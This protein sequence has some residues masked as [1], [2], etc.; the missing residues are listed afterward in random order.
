MMKIE[1]NKETMFWD[2]LFDKEQSL[3]AF[4][5]IKGKRR[6]IHKLTGPKDLLSSFPPLFSEADEEEK[7]RLLCCVPDCLQ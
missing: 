6:A 3:V 4:S 7:G 5:F 2:F 1:R